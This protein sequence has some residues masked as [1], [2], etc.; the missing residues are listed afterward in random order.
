MKKTRSIQVIKDLD[1]KNIVIINDVI[2]KGKKHINWKDVEEY[3][4]K[5]IGEFYEVAKTKD[6]IYIGKDLPR[7]YTRSRYT[8]S[9]RRSS[10]KTKANIIQ[11]IPEL[12]EI[13]TNKSYKENNK[14]RNALKAENGWYKYNTRFA[15]P[16]YDNDGN[17]VNYSIYK[18]MLIIRASNDNKLY[19]YD[20][21]QIFKVK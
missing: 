11:V 15:F 10:A 20:V 7:E 19:L 14:S 13:A 12:I 1:D 17:I 16:V 21:I 9:L 8:K 3:L 6:I 4:K 2:F 5:Y 18:A